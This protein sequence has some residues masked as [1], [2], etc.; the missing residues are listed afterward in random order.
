MVIDDDEIE[1]SRVQDQAL[2]VGGKREEASVR[3]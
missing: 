2:S 1:D 3:K